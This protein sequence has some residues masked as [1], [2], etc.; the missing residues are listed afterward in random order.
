MKKE[1]IEIDDLTPK[2]LSDILMEES[3]NELKNSMLFGCQGPFVTMSKVHTLTASY[4][5][6]IADGEYKPVIN[7]HWVDVNDFVNIGNG[8]HTEC[9]HCHTW[10]KDKTNYCPNC[11]APMDGKREQK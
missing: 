11:G 10:S 9:S 3:E 2:E 8:I 7:A 6:K 5:R 1:D 4:L